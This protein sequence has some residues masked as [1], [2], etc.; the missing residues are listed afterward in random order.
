MPGLFYILEKAGLPWCQSESVEPAARRVIEP[1]SNDSPKP[2][3]GH[4]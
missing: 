2:R 4:L 3:I 1:R